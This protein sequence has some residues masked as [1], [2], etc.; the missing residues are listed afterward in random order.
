M[1]AWVIGMHGV[2]D[3]GSTVASSVCLVSVR[4]VTALPDL[5]CVPVIILTIYTCVNSI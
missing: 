5:F 1:I 4:G 2:P 3:F